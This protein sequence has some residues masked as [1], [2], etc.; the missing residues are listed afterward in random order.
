MS[1]FHSDNHS[2]LMANPHSINRATGDGT[3]DD[4]AAINSA[5]T[6]G[7]R[8]GKGCESSTISPA[9]IYFPPGTYSIS[10]PLVQLYYTQFIGDALSLP[11]I[12]AT[13]EFDGIALIDADPYD[14]K[15]NNWQDPS[16]DGYV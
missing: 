7:A 1:G 2:H 5:I 15:G 14:D 12:Q 11:T 6:D 4:T 10:S 8:C 3:T 13:A 16:G 9:I